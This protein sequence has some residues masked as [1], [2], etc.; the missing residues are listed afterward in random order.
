MCADGW[1]LPKED[2]NGECEDCGCPT[3]DGEAQH[4]CHYGDKDCE[5]CGHRP[6]VGSC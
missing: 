1:C 5:S 3:V 2:V 4:G 6:C